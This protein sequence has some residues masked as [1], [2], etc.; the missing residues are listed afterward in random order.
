MAHI[1]TERCVDCRYTDC[2][3]VC[4]VDCF[5]EVTSPAM[6]VIDPDTCIDCGLCVPE[7]PIQAIWPADELPEV[8]SEWTDKNADLFG[9]GTKIKI[10][11]DALPSALPLPQIQAREKQRGWAIQE[12]KGAKGGGHE[13]AA[14]AAPA[15]APAPSSNVPVP[16]GLSGSL[17]A[18]YQATANPRYRWRTAAGVAKEVRLPRGTVEGDLEKLV[19]LGHVKKMPPKTRGLAAYALAKVA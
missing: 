18:V 12:P 3:V 19:S 14:E 11:K 2:C 16:E 5:Y 9:D 17:V 8:Y 6:L 1:V 4:P 15:A 10:K 13:G 7:C